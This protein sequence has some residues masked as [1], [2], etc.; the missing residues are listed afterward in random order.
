MW[1]NAYLS[2]KAGPGSW[3]QITHFAH[4]TA[5]YYVGKIWPFEAGA[6]LDQILDLHLGGR[7]L[8]MVLYHSMNVG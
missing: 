6:P 8:R 4:M 7:S 1:E 5:L 3:S 2:I